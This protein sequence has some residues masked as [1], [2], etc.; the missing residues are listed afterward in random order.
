MKVLWISILVL[1]LY[2]GYVYTEETNDENGDVKNSQSSTECQC[3]E[4]DTWSGFSACSKHCGRGKQGRSRTRHCNQTVA[5]TSQGEVSCTRHATQYRFCNTQDC[6][7]DVVCSPWSGWTNGT[8]S[9][10]CGG[11]SL[12]R[13]RYR[14]CQGNQGC[15]EQDQNLI[16]CNIKPCSQCSCD[17][18]SSWSSYGLC[19]VTCG[20]GVQIRNRKRVCRSLAIGQNCTSATVETSTSPCN[21][22]VCCDEICL[23]WS[24]WRNDSCSVTC[25]EGT[26]ARSRTR[27][28]PLQ[29][30]AEQSTE[31]DSCKKETC[32]STCETTCSPWGNVTTSPCTVTC[33]GG[34]RLHTSVRNCIHSDCVSENVMED[35]CN[36]H[37]CQRTCDVD[38]GSW[39][40]WSEGNCSSVCDDG[41]R[42]RYR[43]RTCPHQDCTKRDRQDDTCRDRTCTGTCDLQCS[44]WGEWQEGNCSKSCDEGVVIRTRFRGC[45]ATVGDCRQKQEVES[46]C[47]L[48]TCSDTCDVNCSLWADWRTGPCSTTCDTGS[49][50]RKRFRKCPAKI[51]DCEHSEQETSPCHLRTCPVTCDRLCNPWSQWMGVV[52]STTCD[53]GVVMRTRVRTCR[54]QNKDCGIYENLTAPC[55]MGTCPDTCDK[56]C[57]SWS[58]WMEIGACSRSCGS[59][60][61]TLQRVRSCGRSDCQALESTHRQCMRGICIDKI[62][63]IRPVCQSSGTFYPH[64]TDCTKFFHCL[65]TIPVELQCPLGTGWVQERG[66]CDYKWRI[67]NC[68]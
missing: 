37:A 39:G 26:S 45:P 30:C 64:L 23:P 34:T 11:G 17:L 59:G 42:T 36:F 10:F 5:M 48:E 15:P 47:Y 49:H 3:S 22:G 6:G 28:C 8:C 24:T 52:C 21:Y 7:C 19:S 29:S 65:W 33:G 41:I 66:V 14:K 68:R 16:P 4:W 18:W 32:Q 55:N 44:P 31:V 67:P 13:T 57:T 51:M 56:N 63:D 43:N 50:L 61:Q 38:C 9:V 2:A 27:L 46:P 40:A 58:P 25:G 53:K 35:S 1:G 54:F 60:L 20:Q 62:K 12:P